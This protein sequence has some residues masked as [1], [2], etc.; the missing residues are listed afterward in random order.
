V[1]FFVER[2]AKREEPGDDFVWGKRFEDSSDDG[3]VATVEVALADCDVGDV[4]ARTSTDQN[5]RAGTRG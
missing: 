2:D 4:A 5:L 1:R 3:R